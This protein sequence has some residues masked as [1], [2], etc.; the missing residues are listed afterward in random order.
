MTCVNWNR[1]L[2]LLQVISNSLRATY[3]CPQSYFTGYHESTVTHLRG[4][5][6]ARQTE[7][8]V[9]TAGT[10]AVTVPAAHT[11]DVTTWSHGSRHDLIVEA[12]CRL[13][14]ILQPGGRGGGEGRGRREKRERRVKRGAQ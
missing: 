9:R 12:L 8:F 13:V 14:G 3:Y 6:G 1:T 10:A 7:L 4:R 5:G 2:S 11:A